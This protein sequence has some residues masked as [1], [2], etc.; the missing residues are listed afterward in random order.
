MEEF[1]KLMIL[2]D[3]L[4]SWNETEATKTISRREKRKNKDEN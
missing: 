3:K 2:L 1:A 4:S